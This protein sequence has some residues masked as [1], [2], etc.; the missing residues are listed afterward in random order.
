MERK[1]PKIKFCHKKSTLPVKSQDN[2]NNISILPAC[3]LRVHRDANCAAGLGINED[4]QFCRIKGCGGAGC[5]P[6][7]FLSSFPPHQYFSKD[8]SYQNKL[9]IVG[10]GIYR[11]VRV[12]LNIGKIFWFR[13]FMSNFREV[14]EIQ[15]IFGSSKEF[16]TL[17]TQT[18]H[19]SFWSGWSG[20]SKCI[21]C[22]AKTPNFAVLRKHFR[23]SRNSLSLL[24]S[25]N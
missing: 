16:Q 8:L 21:I 22:L 19:I 14:V 6:S 13:D 7:P 4:T 20:D 25:W 24:S 23:I 3:R 15:A 18:Y 12:I 9:Y 2:W 10:K 11:R 1:T 5:P 17:R